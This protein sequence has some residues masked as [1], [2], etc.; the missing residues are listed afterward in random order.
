MKPLMITIAYLALFVM[1]LVLCSWHNDFPIAYHADEAGKVLQVTG[2]VERNHRH[3]PLL[4]DLTAVFH[5]ITGQ[6]NNLPEVVA[7]GRWVSAIAGATA[8]VMLA[9]TAH[10]LAG[11]LAAFF[12]GVMIGCCP[13]LTVFSHYM[14]EDGLLLMG[15]ASVFLTATFFWIKARW[16]S[17]AMLAVACVLALLAKYIGVV[18]LLCGLAIGLI[19]LLKIKKRRRIAVVLGFVIGF[20]LAAATLGYHW[21]S[22]MAQA[23][24]GVNFELK[25]V[26]HGHFDLSYTRLGI[27]GYYTKTLL[28]ML[29]YWPILPAVIGMAWMV[30]DKRSTVRAI[31]RLVVIF[32]VIY[33]VLLL[34]GYIAA[35]RYL[36]PVVIMC[37]WFAG[38]FLAL[39]VSTFKRK[40]QRQQFA[41]GLSLLIVAVMG[42]RG[43]QVIYQFD[44]DG[45]PAMAQWVQNNL[46]A[47]AYIVEDMYCAM[48]DQRNPVMVELYGQWQ[49]RI[50]MARNAAEFGTVDQLRAMGVTHVAVCDYNYQRFLETNGLIPNAADTKAQARVK[51]CRTFYSQLFEQCPVVWAH[52]PRY[53]LAGLTSPTLVIF[54]L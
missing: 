15:I 47:S 10:L 27:L 17:A 32:A 37:S 39:W 36:I 38:L 14:K 45:R 54:K 21:W 43:Y 5:R 3:P 4:L 25:H 30:R 46:D 1:T 41:W 8:T 29:Y 49:P 2:Q 50:R 13:A 40:I 6:G 24:G 33:S 20:I 52:Q 51:H 18:A 19:R 34:S 26:S 28:A 23:V 16:W 48:P 31:G 11:R 12:V 9:V 42:Y 7:S 22:D 35:D 53:K 44:H